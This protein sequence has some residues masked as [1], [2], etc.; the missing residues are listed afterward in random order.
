MERIKGFSDG[1]EG[2]CSYRD[3]CERE[4]RKGRVKL[5]QGRCEWGS[6]CEASACEDG[7]L[8]VHVGM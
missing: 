5:G 2:L 4:A 6:A 3:G 1:G 8:Q 7:E